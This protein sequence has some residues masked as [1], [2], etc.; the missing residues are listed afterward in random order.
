MIPGLTFLNLF[1]V[2][3]VLSV[4]LV[5]V[6]TWIIIFIEKLINRRIEERIKS[7]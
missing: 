5:T 6:I 3:V 1:E 7:K 2:D 4:W